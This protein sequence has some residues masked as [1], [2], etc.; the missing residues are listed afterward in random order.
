[1]SL[2]LDQLQKSFGQGATRLSILDQLS[3]LV[4]RG[5]SLAIV[6]E[7]GSGKSTLLSLIAGFEPPDAGDIQ[8]NGQS[9]RGWGDDQWSQFRCKNLGFVFQNYHLIPY[10]TALENVELPLRLL[11]RDDYRTQAQ[12]LLE[13]LD[14]ARRKDHLPHQLSGGERQRIAIARA[15]I[16]RP[17]L[18][19]ADEPTGS[20]DAKTG[21]QVLQLLFAMLK[22][23]Q[24]TA[25]VVTHSQEVAARCDRRLTLRQGRLWSE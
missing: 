16:H 22:D 25:L 1:M 13:R 18:L 23:L 2:Q 15:L 7:S 17:E 21:G 11:Q 19:L 12:A 14:L 24:Q 4:E 8:W 6:G 9:T 10:L 5:E 3:L 20:L